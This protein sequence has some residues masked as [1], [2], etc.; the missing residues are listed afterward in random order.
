MITVSNTLTAA[1][2]HLQTEGAGHSIAAAND[3]RSLSQGSPMIQD[4]SSS[5][6]STRIAGAR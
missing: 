1:L 4:A 6:A 2:A 3:V 5:P